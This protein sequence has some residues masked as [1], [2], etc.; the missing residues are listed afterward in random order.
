MSRF[1]R[2][3][4]LAFSALATLLASAPAGAGGPA[5]SISE[6]PLERRPFPRGKTLFVELAPER[7]GVRTENKYADPRMWTDLYQEFLF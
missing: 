6:K 5:G 3:A 4:A 2:T 7:T 1:S